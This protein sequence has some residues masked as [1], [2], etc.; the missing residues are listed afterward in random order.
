MNRSIEL[1]NRV[2]D[3]I[4]KWSESDNYRNTRKLRRYTLSKGN[5]NWIPTPPAIFVG[6]GTSLG[7][8]ENGGDGLRIRI[9]PATCY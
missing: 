9:S 8:D 7:K 5:K 3:S 6:S 1:G 2:A 4:L